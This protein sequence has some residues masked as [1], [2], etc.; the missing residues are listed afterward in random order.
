MVQRR[1]ASQST[2]RSASV[3]PK[4]PPNRHHSLG[5]MTSIIMGIITRV[6]SWMAM[7]RSPRPRL[8]TRCD[9]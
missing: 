2:T 3:L 1:R 9:R 5:N 4:H 7:P 8:I 6:S